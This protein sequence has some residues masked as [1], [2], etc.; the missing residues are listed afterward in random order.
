[1]NLPFLTNVLFLAKKLLVLAI[2]NI[3]IVLGVNQR[4]ASQLEVV[5]VLLQLLKNELF[6]TSQKLCIVMC[7][8]VLSEG[9][10]EHSIFQLS[11]HTYLSTNITLNFRIFIYKEN[12]SFA[13]IRIF[14]ILHAYIRIFY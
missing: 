3:I 12:S 2:R 11:I 10:S 4:V 14:Q 5:P 6:D 9:N 13:N 8:A 7:L 1:M